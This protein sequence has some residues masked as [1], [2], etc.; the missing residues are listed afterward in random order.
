MSRPAWLG[1]VVGLIG[2]VTMV[3]G[4]VQMAFPAFVLKIVGGETGP[5]STHFFAIVGMFMAFFGGLALHGVVAGSAP[6]LLWSGLQ[7][8]GAA[9]AV[10]LGI[11]HGVFSPVAMPVAIFDLVSALLILLYCWKV[12]A[13]N[14]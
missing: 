1:W 7:K 13:A 11:H 4:A 10:A 12:G 2:V 8:L 5:A 14:R 6:A 9:A 3:T